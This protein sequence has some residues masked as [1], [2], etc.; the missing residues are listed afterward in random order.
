[1]G[2]LIVP[3]RES[4]DKGPADLWVDVQ[5]CCSLGHTSIYIHIIVKEEYHTA[6]CRINQDLID[7]QC[8]ILRFTAFEYVI[9]WRKER[10]GE[11]EKAR[12]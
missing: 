4:E 2:G 10:E 3:V 11:I 6:K 12:P 1:M 5:Q 7:S 8:F 9:E